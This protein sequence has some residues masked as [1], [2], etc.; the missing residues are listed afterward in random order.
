MYGTHISQLVMR[1]SLRLAFNSAEGLAWS[2]LKNVFMIVSTR[3]HMYMNAAYY[4][5]R[6]ISGTY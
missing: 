4:T 1:N 3:Q 2:S 5:L 6:E